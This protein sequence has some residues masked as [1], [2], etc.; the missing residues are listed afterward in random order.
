[1]GVRPTRIIDRVSLPA[2]AV[3]A[4]RESCEKSAWLRVW[5]TEFADVSRASPL[6]KYAAQ[7]MWVACQLSATACS[8]LSMGTTQTTKRARLVRSPLYRFA[9]EDVTYTAEGERRSDS[10]DILVTLH[11]G[12]P[13]ERVL[14]SVTVKRDLDVH[15]SV[16]IMDAAR[17]LLPT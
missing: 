8:L 4:T 9:V 6:T 2:G 12:Y 1:M 15:Q 11:L 14:G 17:R 16:T 13:R 3:K 10:D 7:H 5:A